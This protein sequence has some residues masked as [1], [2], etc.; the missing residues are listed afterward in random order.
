MLT[1]YK[2]KEQKYLFTDALKY[3]LFRDP[4]SFS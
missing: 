1:T 3:M 4:L 2:T